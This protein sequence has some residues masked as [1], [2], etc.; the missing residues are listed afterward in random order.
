M[1]E[2]QDKVAELMMRGHSDFEILKRMGVHSFERRYAYKKTFDFLTKGRK[3]L[4]EIDIKNMYAKVHMELKDEDLTYLMAIMNPHEL[5]LRNTSSFVRFALFLE[6]RVFSQE[7]EHALEDA[8]YMFTEIGDRKHWHEVPDDDI[9]M[10][11]DQLS[12]GLKFLGERADDLISQEQL[13]HMDGF[14]KHFSNILNAPACPLRRPGGNSL[15]RKAM[16]IH[17]DSTSKEYAMYFKMLRMHIPIQ[18]MMYKATLNGMGEAEMLALKL[19][20][21]RAS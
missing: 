21:E 10:T 4:R 7:I 14:R 20:L 9:V 19:A 13:L 2:H 17:I 6:K 16:A 5:E 3:T 15:L 18:S 12:H 1:E 11:K 8:F